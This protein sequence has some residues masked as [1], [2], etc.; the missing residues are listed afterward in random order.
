MDGIDS[1]VLIRDDGELCDMRIL[2]DDIG[3]EYADAG[4]QG[5]RTQLLLTTPRYALGKSSG[6]HQLPDCQVHIVVATD[7][8]K[9]I[10]AQLGR[11][12]CNYVVEQSF[13]SAALQL[14]ILHSLYRGPE[15]RRRNRVAM[16]VECKL[17]VGWRARTA[18]LVQLSDRGC[19]VMLPG[20]CDS[21]APIVL[22]VP[23]SATGTSAMTLRGNVVS[24]ARV[25]GKNTNLAISFS[26]LNGAKSRAI[27]QLMIR[28][29]LGGHQMAPIDESKRQRSRPPASAERPRAGAKA[30]PSAAATPAD[31]R[32]TPR[33]EYDNRVLA[34]GNGEATAVIGRDLSIGG[35]LA[36]ACDGFDI[37]DRFKLIL[38]GHEDSDPIIVRAEV[39]RSTEEGIALQFDEM[40]TDTKRRLE[41]LVKSLPVLAPDGEGSPGR[42]IVVGEAIDQS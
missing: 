15:R 42:S 10:R 28:H 29:T 40:R 39:L 1:E 14:L 16:T 6:R 25:K 12:D 5:G 11:F 31:R 8:S 19:G 24:A 27:R 34:A 26:E 36:E 7:F 18:T 13:H 23:K 2:L 20:E 38:F 30:K 4:E 41:E 17:K 21:G 9:T 35:M 32:T 37:G 3:V 22:T 33:A